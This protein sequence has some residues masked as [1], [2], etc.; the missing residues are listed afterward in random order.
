VVAS[1]VNKGQLTM[2]APPQHVTILVMER[3]KN[4]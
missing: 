4:V 1:G 3:T 2:R